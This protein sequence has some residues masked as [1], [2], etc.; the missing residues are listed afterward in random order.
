[1]S[2]RGGYD[3]LVSKIIITSGTQQNTLNEQ[4][5]RDIINCITESRDRHE[6]S[7]NFELVKRYNG[8]LTKLEPLEK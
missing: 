7:K 1:M 3:Q 2:S 6:Q 4:E 5:L 8:L